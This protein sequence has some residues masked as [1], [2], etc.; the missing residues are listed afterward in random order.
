MSQFFIKIHTLTLLPRTSFLSRKYR[1]L[2]VLMKQ[3]PYYCAVGADKAFGRDIV[4][5]HYKACLYSGL[6]IGGANGEVMPGQW[7][8]QI[9]PTVGIG[10]GDQLWVARYILEVRNP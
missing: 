8:F 7:E 2:Y 6:S 10:A 3:G 5:A 1:F 4:D 9:S